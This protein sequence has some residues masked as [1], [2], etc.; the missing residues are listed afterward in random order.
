VH[1]VHFATLS[2]FV[3]K[4]MVGGRDKVLMYVQ[5]TMEGGGLILG[6]VFQRDGAHPEFA[7][8]PCARGVPV[9]YP[10]HALH[11]RMMQQRRLAG[12]VFTLLRS[13]FCL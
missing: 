6:P 2:Q 9:P 3:Y 5:Y 10:S 8:V 1:L 4:H 13:L 11:K 7:P 12:A